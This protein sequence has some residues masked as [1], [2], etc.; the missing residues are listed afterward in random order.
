M[1]SN[2][3]WLS[4]ALFGLTGCRD[5]SDQLRSDASIQ[6]IESANASQ[7]VAKERER[8]IGNAMEATLKH[9]Q[10]I[11]KG[12]KGNFRGVFRGDGFKLNYFLNFLPNVQPY[13]G[14]RVRTQAEIA[15]DLDRLGMKVEFK[16]SAGEV[17]FGCVFT[18]VRPDENSGE[19]FLMAE[20]CPYSIR[21]WFSDESRGSDSDHPDVLSAQLTEQ[22]MEG[23]IESIQTL[24][25]EGFSVIT[26]K[27]FRTS[28]DKI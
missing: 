17:N 27:T 18:D 19:I 23:K 9:R 15:S 24:F 25:F 7:R 21:L 11:Y 8:E 3:F 1:R 26:G 14:S 10:R 5:A 16:V 4:I 22:L 28:L 6:G 13:N 12:I 2:Y 20:K